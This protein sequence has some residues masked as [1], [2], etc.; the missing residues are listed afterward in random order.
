MIA[1]FIPYH[2]LHVKFQT[3][4]YIRG[5][6]KSGKMGL[7]MHFNKVY[8]L[9]MVSYYLVDNFYHINAYPRDRLLSPFRKIQIYI[10]FFKNLCFKLKPDNDSNYVK[11]KSVLKIIIRP[12]MQF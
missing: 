10:E 1:I 4:F 6:G 3:F 7:E 8:L 12:F 11:S 9:I 2:G 5:G